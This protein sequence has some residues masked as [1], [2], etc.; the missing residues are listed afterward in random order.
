MDPY[1][2]APPFFPQSIM[3]TL[4]PSNRTKTT[5]KK[6]KEMKINSQNSVKSLLFLLLRIRKFSHSRSMRREVIDTPTV[7]HQCGCAQAY[8]ALLLD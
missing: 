6:K 3:S 2:C 4:V 7:H 5:G 1:I 8:A